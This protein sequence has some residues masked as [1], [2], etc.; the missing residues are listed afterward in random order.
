MMY[1][2]EV[3]GLMEKDSKQIQRVQLTFLEVN[4]KF[5][6]ISLE[7]EADGCQLGGCYS[8]GPLDCG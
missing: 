8:Y 2:C 4:S 7:L 1:G 3:W 6:I 5:P